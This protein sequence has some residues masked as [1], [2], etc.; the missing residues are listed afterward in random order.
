MN[1]T[2]T[3]TSPPPLPLRYVPRILLFIYFLF[4]FPSKVLQDSFSVLRGTQV[5][6][7]YPTVLPR[8][9]GSTYGNDI[10]IVELRVTALGLEIDDLLIMSAERFKMKG[11]TLLSWTYFAFSLTCTFA[12]TLLS[13]SLGRGAD[14]LAEKLSCCGACSRAQVG[15]C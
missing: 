13:S 14:D 1:L 9:R 3:L 10:A 12:F 5:D 8:V 2:V 11:T 15:R 6:V 4:R 7:N